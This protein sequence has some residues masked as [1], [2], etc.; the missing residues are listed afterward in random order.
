MTALSPPRP[1]SLTPTGTVGPL[2]ARPQSPPAA[3][4]SSLA[5]LRV[6]A[7]SVV[8]G[9]P[10]PAQAPLRDRRATEVP[11][12]S[13]VDFLVP[14]SCSRSSSSRLRSVP[15]PYPVSAPSAPIT[16]ARHDDRNGVAAVGQSHR[17]PGG[18]LVDATRELAVADR[19][20]VGD[21]L[22]RTPDASLERRAVH[23]ERQIE[24]GAL[25]R[26]VVGQ[27]AARIGECGGIVPP[28][29]GDRHG[30]A[31]GLHA[32]AV[33]RALVADQEQLADRTLRR[34][35]AERP[36]RGGRR[37][38][39][40]AASRSGARSAPSSRATA[41]PVPSRAQRCARRRRGRGAS[42]RRVARR[43]GRRPLRAARGRD[44]RRGRSG[45]RRRGRAGRAWRRTPLSRLHAPP[46]PRELAVARAPVRPNP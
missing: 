13:Y 33:Q 46:R 24:A 22:Q 6:L 29:R 34:G 1:P 27:L 11:G 42:A 3:R 23:D 25:A 40:H 4:A 36:G 18:G 19:L 44:G 30:R 43:R 38:P 31:P 20:A 37:W 17:P 7:I 45:G 35:V 16:R 5:R 15:P 8:Q 2:T 9:R 32:Q 12:V 21:V 14:A 41:R 28:F 39:P 26:E 10:V